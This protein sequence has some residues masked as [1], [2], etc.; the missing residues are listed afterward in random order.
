MN[1]NIIEAGITSFDNYE[2]LYS[3]SPSGEGHLVQ[4]LNNA[5]VKHL[6]SGLKCKINWKEK[7]ESISSV[8]FLMPT[9]EAKLGNIFE[10]C[11]YG[12][13]KKNRT[14][15][16][17]TTLELNSKRNSIVVVPT[18]S[19]AYNKAKNSRIGHSNN[20]GILYVGG[21]ISGFSTP[22]IENYLDNPAILYKKFIVV[23]DSLPRLL[24]KIG[25]DNYEDYF[26]MVDEVD[27]YQYD[28]YFRES[29]ENVIDYYF[30]FP[31]RNRCLVSATIGVFSNKKIEDEPVI[32]ISFNRSQRRNIALVHTNNVIKTAAKQIEKTIHDYP[33]GK[34]LI[35]FNS[36]RNGILQIIANLDNS[37][38][39]KCAVLCGSY[40]QTYAGEYY[41]EIID[42]MLPKQI[43]F[44]TCT[45][46]VGIDISE[47]FHLISISESTA[48][49]THT[50]LSEDRLEQI[51][52][53]CRIQDGVYSETIVYKSREIEP[54][55]YPSSNSLS[56]EDIKIKILQDA[57]TLIN[58]INTIPK[59]DEIF[60]H[61]RPWLRNTNIDDIIHNSIYKYNDL[62]P[63]K[64]LR[65]N[66]NGEVQVAY[67]NIDNILIQHNTLT[68]LY[69]TKHA[70]R[71]IL[72]SR[73]HIITW[74]DI[75]EEA[76][77]ISPQNQE[78][79]NEHI[80][81]VEENETE[82][83]IGHLRNGNSIQE[84]ASLANDFKF[85]SHPSPNGKQF[86]DRFLELQIFVD[87]DS[88][89]EK[90]TQ[91]MTSNQYNALYNSVKFWALSE[92]HPFKIIF[93]EKFPLG[94][95]ITGRDILENLNTIFSSLGLMSVES[96]KKAISYM[97]MFCTLSDRIRDRS[98]GNVY[99]ILEYNV[100]GF[101]GEPASIIE[102]NIPIS[103]LFRF[104]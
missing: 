6:E 47:Q 18:R 37:L 12:I 23:A 39:S 96:N 77:R 88:I 101:H 42:E 40:S 53:R 11:P 94:T 80:T 9:D 84:R 63:V 32:N 10:E 1:N 45:Y 81:R 74:Q 73:G 35:A 49:Q 86:I 46:F 57:S 87:F 22:T 60:L 68:Y 93:K 5:S 7:D 99:E 25:V 103:G 61:L 4:Y 54:D 26:F 24:G 43:T 34:I 13:I 52:G 59:L 3:S 67:L 97:K 16:G 48:Q 36:V 33:E 90:L 91:R 64:L 27:S 17:A 51:V 82:R 56:Q 72:S 31:Y 20:Y 29:L 102:A 30:E 100:N 38:K 89:T 95:R 75:H 83:I 62:K 15:V 65:S 76:G 55:T 71:Y 78:N 14:G 104:T 41:S 92:R 58:H 2:I 19:L 50:L 69:L 8:S 28:G 85:N 98:R 44:M 70:L 66:I 79:I 21:S